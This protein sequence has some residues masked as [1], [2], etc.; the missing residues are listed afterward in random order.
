LASVLQPLDVPA[1]AWQT[2]SMD[3]ISGLP[4]FG[5]A[6]NILVSLDKFTKY[7]HFLPIH[8]PYIAISIAQLFID[9][10]YKLHGLPLAISSDR[11]LVLIDK[12]VLEVF[13]P[14]GFLGTY[15]H[16]TPK[17]DGQIQQVNQCLGTYFQCFV[18][19]CPSRW[20]RWLLLAEH[21]YN[22]SCHSFVGTSPFEVLYG[23]K[24]IHFGL[25]VTEVTVLSDLSSWLKERSLMQALVCQ[26]ICCMLSNK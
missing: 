6:N 3:F 24:P 2:I 8:H 23:H 13:S 21:W 14:D 10:I 16:T 18:H 9:H 12:L 20:L 5:H 4:K 11:D 1:A 25:S 19:A 22:T 17:T 7:N 15:L 26:H